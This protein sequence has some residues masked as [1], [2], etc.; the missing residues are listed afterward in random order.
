MHEKAGDSCP[1]HSLAPLLRQ[2]VVVR[3]R[4][5]KDG[6]KE[7]KKG[8]AKSKEAA[9]KMKQFGFSSGDE[10]EEEEDAPKPK[11][12]CMRLALSMVCSVGREESGL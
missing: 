10:E 9:E 11:K 2:E 1:F 6:S 5:F 7:A 4:F 3:S 8:S 12:V